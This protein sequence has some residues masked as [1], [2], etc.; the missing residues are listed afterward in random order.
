MYLKW[1]VTWSQFPPKNRTN[2]NYRFPE[3]RPS[4]ALARFS[5]A[6]SCAPSLSRPPSR[7]PPLSSLHALYFPPVDLLLFALGQRCAQAQCRTHCRG[8]PAFCWRRAEEVE[9]RAV[10]RILL[11]PIRPRCSGRHFLY[12][13]RP[14]HCSGRHLHSWEKTSFSPAENPSTP[15]LG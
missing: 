10:W 5:L 14:P 13:H 9:T 12:F 8:L 11:R 3:T 6:L 15:L 4:P 2:P 7:T 1:T